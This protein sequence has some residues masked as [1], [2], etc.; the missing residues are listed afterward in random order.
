MEIALGTATGLAGVAA[1]LV[2]GRR[3]WGEPSSRIAPRQATRTPPVAEPHPSEEREPVNEAEMA[4]HTRGAEQ[5]ASAAPAADADA[6]ESAKRPETSGPVAERERLV[7]GCIEL[8]DRLLTVNPA[9]WE[10]LNGELAGVGV[11][12]VV[13]DGERYDRE[14]HDALDKEPTDDP[15]RHLTVASTE[16][17]GYLDHGRLLR[18]PQVIVYRKEE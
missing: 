9:L 14:A 8:G 13:A 18:R 1:G 3:I 10:R 17:P 11:H 2:L 7:S 4:L 15:D 6:V 5:S 12:A 16:F